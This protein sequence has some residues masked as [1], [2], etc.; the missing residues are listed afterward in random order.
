[1]RSPDELR[2]LAEA[3]VGDLALTP[4]LGAL[5]ESL[6]YATAG[7]KRVRATICLATAE[8]SGAEADSALPAAAALELVHAFC[9]STTTCPRSTTIA[10]GG[11]GRARGRASARRS[12]SS[13]GTRSLLRPSGWRSRIRPQQLRVSSPRRRSG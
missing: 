10:S 8:A 7:G 13:P 2:A 5:Q 11:A 12:G 9:S 4:E 6:R 1:M 3:Y